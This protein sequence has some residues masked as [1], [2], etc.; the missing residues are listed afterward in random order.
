MTPLDAFKAHLNITDDAD[1][2]VLGQSLDAATAWIE[3][4]TGGPLDPVP[5]PVAQATRMLAGSLFENREATIAGVSAQEVPF[6]VMD[7]LEPYR[8]WY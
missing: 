1:D 3:R 6:G 5:A 8:A 7:L 2:I 4:M